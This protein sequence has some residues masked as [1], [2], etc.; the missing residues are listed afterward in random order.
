MPSGR[1]W[2]G[3]RKT[4]SAKTRTSWNR[5]N[6]LTTRR[7]PIGTMKC[8]R[9]C[10]TFVVSWLAAGYQIKLEAPLLGLVRLRRK[11][12]CQLHRASNFQGGVLTKAYAP[13]GQVPGERSRAPVARRTRDQ[14]GDRLGKIKVTVAVRTGARETKEGRSGGIERMQLRRG[15]R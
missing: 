12:K 14:F 4:S 5:N 6:W 7:A 2:S 10:G 9:R 8:S 15:L 3:S 13:A 11:P 1:S